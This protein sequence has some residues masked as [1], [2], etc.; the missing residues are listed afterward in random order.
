MI[1][2]RAKLGKLSAVTRGGKELDKKNLR[3]Y[4]KTEARKKLE[5]LPSGIGGIGD[6]GIL[7]GRVAQFG[8]KV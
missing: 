8:N 2:K 3:R 6:I 1:Q 7:S 4:F 5:L